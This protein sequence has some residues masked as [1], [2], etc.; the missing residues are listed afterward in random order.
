MDVGLPYSQRNRAGLVTASLAQPLI[1]DSAEAA[2]DGLLVEL[3]I[4]RSI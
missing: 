1:S 4:Q 3:D 2:N